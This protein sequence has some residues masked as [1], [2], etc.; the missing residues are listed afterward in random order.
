[1]PRRIYNFSQFLGESYFIKEEKMNFGKF[2]D[3]V[4]KFGSDMSNWFSNL[5][6]AIKD[7]IFG[8]I[9]SGPKAGTSVIKLYLPEDGDIVS[10]IKTVCRLRS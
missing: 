5:K 3:S 7:K 10:Q 4:K 9:K 8:V 1:M 2:G 6:K